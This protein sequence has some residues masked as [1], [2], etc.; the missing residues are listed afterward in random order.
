MINLRSDL[1][2][3][4]FTNGTDYPVLKAQSAVINNTGLPILKSN[5][6]D[7]N[8][9]TFLIFLSFLLMQIRIGRCFRCC[10]L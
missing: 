2:A 6:M 9:F 3:M 1:I 10:F 4:F 8:L 5:L 7:E